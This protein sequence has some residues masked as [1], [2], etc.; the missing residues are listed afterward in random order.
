[1]LPEYLITKIR[2][3]YPN[4]HPKIIRGYEKRRVV[5][6]RINTL[7]TSITDLLKY[8]S[9][10]SISYTKVPWSN[11]SLI[12]NNFYE[13]DL[14]K[15]SIYEEGKIYLQS[16]SSQLP[17]LFLSPQKNETILDMASAPGGK[18]TE[19]A[20][21]SNNQAMI[22]ALEKNKIRFTKLQYNIAKQGAKKITAL[23]IDARFLDKFFLFDK[24]LLDA[25]CTGSGTPDSTHNY[26]LTAEYLTKNTK[27]QKE[28]L[29]NA[30]KHCRQGGIIIYSTCSILKEENEDILKYFLNQ[31]QVEIVP[32]TLKGIIELPSTINGV[33]TICPTSEYEGFFIAK[34][35]KL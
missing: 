5:T 20:A 15:L 17:P 23:N 4:D 7:K 10:H 1:M 31:K 22:T 12:V 11:F 18:T 21:L 16:L 25:P 8:L 6:I 28:L 34:L 13:E 3:E 14:T 29:E 9:V 32:L 24:I 30:I 35:K 19:I 26:N 2:A 27:R 33:I